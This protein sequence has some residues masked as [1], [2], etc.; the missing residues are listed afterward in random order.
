MISGVLLAAFLP[1]FSFG[2]FVKPAK[3]FRHG[4]KKLLVW[5][6]TFRFVT[7][8]IVVTR[9]GGSRNQ[10]KTSENPQLPQ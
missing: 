5:V 4:T 2:L 3:I 10:E 8:A 7:H 9:K 1:A 6:R